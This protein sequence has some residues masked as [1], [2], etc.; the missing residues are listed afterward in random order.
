[1][2]KNISKITVLSLFAATLVALPTLSRAEGTGAN[3]P[4]ASDQ[5]A[6]AKTKKHEGLVLRG[7]VSAI[8]TNAMT[9]KVETRTFG[10]TADTKIA[11]DGQPA[12]LADGMVGEPV[13]GAYKKADD[14]KLT[15][16]TIHF[17]A[18]AEKKKPEAAAK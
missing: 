7:T 11:K 1:M 8:D 17:G 12:T 15:A 18:K 5:T 3:P 10:I 9:L 2:R 16:T 6:P 4:A 14:G 13:S